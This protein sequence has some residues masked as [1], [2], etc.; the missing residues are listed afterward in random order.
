MLF[1]VFLSALAPITYLVRIGTV[2]FVRID[3]GMDQVN[4]QLGVLAHVVPEFRAVEVHF[5]ML[6]CDLF[7]ALLQAGGT[8]AVVLFFSH[9]VI[10]K[11]ALL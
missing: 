1:P 10:F 7:H 3:A 6:N 11:S 5:G 9:F 2:A 8:P 4:H